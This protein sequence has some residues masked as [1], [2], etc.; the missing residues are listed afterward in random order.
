MPNS[1]CGCFTDFN[2]CL[3]STVLYGDENQMR[4]TT[5]QEAGQ[6][7][8]M[9]MM[10]CRW[11]L[12][13]LTNIFSIAPNTG[14][15][16]SNSPNSLPSSLIFN[17]AD[18]LRFD[19]A[20]RFGTVPWPQWSVRGRAQFRIRAQFPKSPLFPSELGTVGLVRACY[21]QSYSGYSHSL[22]GEDTSEASKGYSVYNQT[23]SE[24][25]CPWSHGFMG[26]FP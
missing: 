23:R 4:L 15:R 13:L 7:K 21:L 6:R 17:L 8:T 16:I 26:N 12:R 22:P 3:C 1:D 14:S 20:P 5:V 25:S 24:W 2:W 10:T 18:L 19:L 9:E 11:L